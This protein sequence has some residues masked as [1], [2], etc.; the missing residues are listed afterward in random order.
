MSWHYLQLPPIASEC[1]RSIFNH[2]NLHDYILCLRF[3]E[4]ATEFY[5][6]IWLIV[7]RF[8]PMLLAH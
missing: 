1:F 7:L 3:R 8:F 6:L 2:T 5:D 4:L